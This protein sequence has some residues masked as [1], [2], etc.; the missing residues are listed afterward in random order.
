MALGLF[1][2]DVGLDSAEPVAGLGLF[3]PDPNAPGPFKRGLR[4]GIADLKSIGG[5]LTMYAGRG[6]GAIGL[7]TLGRATEAKGLEIYQAAQEA[8]AP[9]RMRVED[10]GKAF[11]TGILPGLSAVSDLV[12][13]T[14]GNQL[15]MLATMVAGGAVGRG[16][17][18]VAGRGATAAAKA[19][20]ERAVATGTAE[21]V[22]A[23]T[24]AAREAT[25]ATTLGADLGIGASAVGMEAGQIFPEAAATGVENPMART[26]AGALVAGALDTVLPAIL[27][28]RMGLIGPNKGILAARK[29]GLG[30]IA[31]EIG[32][33][34]GAAGLFETATEGAQTVIERLAAGQPLS[35]DEASS[36]YLNSAV[37]G[38]IMGLLTGGLAGGI[39][40]ARQPIQAPQEAAPPVI[41]PPA[42]T[43]PII[44]TL[45]P[46]FAPLTEPTPKGIVTPTGEVVPRVVAPVPVSDVIETGAPKPVDT[47]SAESMIAQ[48]KQQLGDLDRTTAQRADIQAIRAKK[49]SGELLDATEMI[50]LREAAKVPKV[51]KASSSLAI[52]NLKKPREVVK[53]P[54]VKAA[55]DRAANVA[56][57][58]VRDA[59]AAKVQGDKKTYTPAEQAK[60]TKR[61][62]DAVNSVVRE[63]AALPSM[64]AG[65]ALILEKVA[66]I[67]GLPE[68]EAV[69]EEVAKTW[70]SRGAFHA[71]P[72]AFTSFDA[73]NIGA[74]E[75]AQS[76]G[77]GIYL[78]ENK[79][80]GLTYKRS[81]GEAAY[82]KQIFDLEAT[83]SALKAQLR[84]DIPRRGVVGLSTEKRGEI[85]QQISNLGKQISEKSAVINRAGNLYSVEI[86]DEWLPNMLD[87][88]KPLSGQSQH[89]KEA[90]QV[91]VRNSGSALTLAE[92]EKNGQ[93]T[94]GIA[95]FL[96]FGS[97]EKGAAALV[98][99][100]IPGVKYLDQGSRGAGAGSYNYVVHPGFEQHIKVKNIQ[101]SA[102]AAVTT[103]ATVNIGLD[104]NDGKGITEAQ[105]LDKLKAI[106]VPAAS[107]VVLRS[108]TEN[109]VVA[110]LPREL[111]DDEAA[112]V[113]ADLGQE[114]ISQY[115][116]GIGKSHGPRAD[117]WVFDPGYFF[118]PDGR[119]L[120][121]ALVEASNAAVD[122]RDGVLTSKGQPMIAELTRMLGN[123]PN[124][125]VQMF[126]A[127]PGEGIGSYTHVDPLKSV[128]SM[129][130]NAADWLG[131]AHHEGFHYAEDRILKDNE[132]AIIARRL[133]PDSEMF[134]RLLV[135]VRQYD[136]E[137][138]T[139]LADEILSIP[140][141]ARAYGYQFWKRGELQVDSALAKIFDKLRQF[142][143][144]ITNFIRGEGFQSIE[145][146][147]DALDRGQYA[148]RARQTDSG[149]MGLTLAS[150]AANT[151]LQSIKAKPGVNFGRLN[152]L[153]G[154]K[155][156]GNPSDLATVS[157]KE[158]VQNSFDAVK[159]ALERGEIEQGRIAIT[160]DKKER[161]ITLEDNGRG[162]TADVLANQFLQLAGT[163]KES[164]QSSGGLGIAKGLF[165]YGNAH[166]TVETTRDGVASKLDS[167]GAIL[168][169]AA[170]DLSLAPEITS[171]R[172][173]GAKNGTSVTVKIPE[174][175]V[176]PATGE[177]KAIEISEW[178]S[179]YPVLRN[180]PLFA[181]IVVS[182]N[183]YKVSDM[184]TEFNKSDY[185][186]FAQVKF[187][188]GRAHIYVS[189]QE[190]ERYGSNLHVLSN[191]LWQF[192]QSLKKNPLDMYGGNLLRNIYVD[193][194]PEVK[195]EDPGY[196]F[197]L[198][199]Q[200]F[201]KQV[202]DDFSSVLTYLSLA[203]NKGEVAKQGKSFGAISYIRPDGTPIATELLAPPIRPETAQQ[204]M[205]IVE[206]DNVEVVE[207]RLIVNGREVPILSKE[208]IKK[209]QI[210]L[211]D[212]V[213]DQ[214]R[215][216]PLQV[217]LHDNVMLGEKGLLSAAAQETFGPKFGRFM[218]TIT[219]ALQELRDGLGSI[220]G[221]EL[222]AKLKEF[223]IGISFD[224]EYRG[225]HIRAPFSGVFI[226]PAGT[227]SSEADKAAYG[228]YL[229]MVHELVHLHQRG[230]DADFVGELQR[231]LS[232]IEVSGLGD[233]IRARLRAGAKAN[234][235][236]L[237]FLH[238]A[239][240]GSDAKARGES[241]PHSGYETRG[242]SRT[243]DFVP[244]GD[245]TERVNSILGS[246][247]SRNTGAQQ[248]G[249]SSAT[250]R[251]TAVT[252]FS[253]AATDIDRQMAHG[254]LIREQGFGIAG[255]MI[256]HAN[257]P[258][259]STKQ[260]LGAAAEGMAGSVERWLYTHITT[261]N[262]V[263]GAS[264]GFKNLRD[265]LLTFVDYK[266]A[267]IREYALTQLSKWNIGSQ[268]AGSQEDITV[269]FKAALDR[270]VGG[271]LVDSPE[272][273]QLR[274]DMTEQQR[275]MFD[276]AFNTT[277]SLLCLEFEADSRLFA[278]LMT[279]EQFARWRVNRK[280]QV[281]GWIAS[282]YIP[283]DR[284]GDFTVTIYADVA[285]ENGETT[286]VAV[287]HQQFTTEAAA[288]VREQQYLV[289]VKKQGLAFGV[290][291]GTV[292][293]TSRDTDISVQQFLDTA[294]RNGVEISQ[295]ERE[296]LAKALT[297]ADSM[298]RNRLIHRENVPGYSRDGSRV[299]NSFVV[300]MANKVAYSE[301]GPAISDAAAGL[302]VDARVELKD[303]PV[304]A[305]TDIAG[306]EVP[307]HMGEGKVRI[308]TDRGQGKNLWIRDGEG[309]GF[310]RNL[311]DG[312]TDFVLVP[313]RT[314]SWS[315]TWRAAT[316]VYMIGG[317]L[318]FGAVN[319]MSVPM[320]LLPA[321]S[322][323]TPYA[324]AFST[325]LSVWKDVW[326]NQATLR[327]ITRLRDADA[328]PLKEIDNI[329]GLRP[330]IID[331]YE[332]MMD[333]EIHQ[334][335][336]MSQGH[337]LSQSRA[338][339][340]AM[341]LWM[342][343]FKISEQTNRFTSFITAYKVGLENKL[344]GRE[345]FEFSKQMVDGTQ[346]NYSEVN[347][348]GAARNPFWAI[349][350]MFKSFPLFMVEAMHS[351][352]KANPK[353]AVYMLLGLVAMS[354][355]Q[356]LPFAEDLLDL[357]DTISQRLFG[358]PFNVRRAMR[359]Y[360]KDASEAFVGAD[361]SEIVLHGL[362]NSMTG[363]NMASRVGMGDM[364]PGTRIGAADGDYGRTAEQLLGA[365]VSMASS[366][367]RGGATLAGGIFGKQDFF[368]SVATALKQ[369]GPVALR[370]VIKGA[371]QLSQ[372]Y[373]ED[374]KGRK[375]VDATGID[376]F[377]QSL[378]FTSAALNRAYE[379]DRVDKQTQAFYVQ[380]RGDFTQQIVR[381]ARDGDT[382]K[383]QE[384]LEAVQAWNTQH[385]DM[386]IGLSPAS[387]RRDIVLGGMPLNERTLRSL[388]R[389]LRG[390]SLS[391]EST[392]LAP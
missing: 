240:N 249:Q 129:A 105:V 228:M 63:A 308:A 96:G 362:V 159:A 236:I 245:R 247:E 191:G 23:A 204:L 178:S 367:I 53:A 182:L 320:I 193:L 198:N 2:K 67:K 360:I 144:R 99:V 117:K 89:V 284:Y 80:T 380:V 297:D 206:G 207:G 37:M 175:Y 52:V 365:P 332:H 324:N 327:D 212:F 57:A 378:G 283:L 9:D 299:L 285:S 194:A 383:I 179:D 337:L 291:R 270:T 51:T 122:Y 316:M 305:Y 223:G 187:N 348:P 359:N 120:S 382:A 276:Q 381:A 216:D 312:L 81:V 106:G 83:R 141:E 97:A 292:H 98:A 379:L 8:S 244:V 218:R 266:E 310:Y 130:L 70:Y 19:A 135:R 368:D 21:D 121:E 256:D 225:V 287:A 205:N 75:G 364:V 180:S 253:K 237:T 103:P 49:A 79:K 91:A 160:V 352:Y 90:L 358:S 166:I 239:L 177:I 85:Q 132:R 391:A 295:E 24:L 220:K 154:A 151:A 44:E 298:Q 46:G 95:D 111:T 288:I 213:V 311:A 257:L 293:K 314:G 231:V 188:W 72:Y 3:A 203:Y 201:T 115:A 138:R 242:T 61:Y 86:P 170:N 148:Q 202:E 127:E 262:K 342:A 234:Q 40:A 197:D 118:L 59:V 142:F 289:E 230:H 184:G 250:A 172:V 27:A 14:A 260:L 217:M 71:S 241:L 219:F 258:I 269:A 39:R 347:R 344:S 363:I 377:W 32:T 307:A 108:D 163:S 340:K 392:G 34:A 41:S 93:T 82:A 221:E 102:A 375:L 112:G 309:S 164:S 87:W 282:G 143:D 43:P 271:F 12:K 353:S 366:I 78:A 251:A 168:M 42:E 119:R 355:V 246:A 107:H 64:D 1:E 48:M 374:L 176:D 183:G 346:N 104:T 88:D 31:K 339:Q 158:M 354:G 333:T 321:L 323:H 133:K 11:D 210:D 47:T 286:R 137:N 173:L 92:L 335:M 330:A 211:A 315:R 131:V 280:A 128:I 147:F 300:R 275:K 4:S 326:A 343:P 18:A 33:T 373:A 296:K 73:S 161:T 345:L 294:R 351:M 384:T 386:P 248:G 162:M 150:E 153:L 167:D 56:Q 94:S 334:I 113:S 259:A 313:D 126:R 155:L 389:Q 349:M 28:R 272:Y 60:L 372:G 328:N 156:Y 371:E 20:A 267:L 336:G 302:P 5:G 189:K 62:T 303:R 22:A 16:L 146:I 209:A 123:D 190:K 66:K 376:A 149:L 318:A 100:G 68:R 322:Q 356:G 261:Q 390:T 385:P 15:P 58:W 45:G 238:G 152:A 101:Q 265:T 306:A 281:D 235:D 165:L 174:N 140:A 233:S 145:D 226:N 13:Y 277:A 329:P 35:G 331:A 29:A 171:S 84:N 224:K 30:A 124:L 74:G 116:N 243:S 255:K 263:A 110:N 387:I 38:G 369:G 65:K 25:R 361:M 77:Y 325:T 264:K 114:A 222:Y 54:D 273:V 76:F 136:L 196:P 229:T 7:D 279:E 274:A 36:D 357:I 26:A 157:I 192:S 139:N 304:E 10:V 186:V 69:A 185:G 350:F 278:S 200:R 17:G 388:P 134:R 227:V 125:E 215:I 301:F 181:N 341:R 55:E 50:R 268:G 195:P 109:T 254:E 6:L 208:D 319:A 199:R 370:N 338:V 232:V 290:V 252:L 214:S 169:Q 317:S